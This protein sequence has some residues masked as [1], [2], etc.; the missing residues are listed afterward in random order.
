MS[1]SGSQSKE[2]IKSE[3]YFRGLEAIL[4]LFQGSAGYFGP[5]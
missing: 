3:A 4:D 5:I 2:H 1:Q